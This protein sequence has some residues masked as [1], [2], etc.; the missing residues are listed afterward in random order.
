MNSAF[1]SLKL[2]QRRAGV[3][4]YSPATIDGDPIM[5]SRKNT[6]RAEG[7]RPSIRRME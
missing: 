6:G 1:L 4:Y 2:G 3:S 5:P 7:G